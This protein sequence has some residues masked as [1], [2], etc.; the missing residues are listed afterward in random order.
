MST[1]GHIKNDMARSLLEGRAPADKINLDIVLDNMLRE[2]CLDADNTDLPES[3][4]WSR[5]DA[6]DKAHA[7]Y[8][9][10]DIGL[11]MNRVKTFYLT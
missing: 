7:A 1:W 9:E 6:L 5:Q 4:W 3:V 10:G 8:R 2:Q 11:C